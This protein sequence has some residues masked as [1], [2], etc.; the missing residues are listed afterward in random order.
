MPYQALSAMAVLTFTFFIG[1]LFILLTLGSQT[2]L[3][4]FETR[5][6]ISAYFEDETSEGNILDLKRNLEAKSYVSQV[7]YISKEAALEIYR[8][9]NKEDELLLEM[10]TADILPASLEISAT[11][12]EQIP[13]IQQELEGLPGIEEVV[14]Q[15]D[16]VEALSKWTGGIR[17]VGL[18]LVLFLVATAM[19][20]VVIIVG[21]KVASRRAEI[22]IMQLLG[23]QKW[24]IVGPFL[25]EGAFYGVVGGF[26]SWIFSFILLLYLTPFLVSFLGDIPLFP[27]DTVVMLLILLGSMVSGILIGMTGSI[28]AVK[29]YFK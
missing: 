23:A 27:L 29:R 2:V 8:E 9:Q 4:Y 14:F 24:F 11:S 10:V 7:D 13:A 25:L 22:G 20:I 26:V 16:V 17:L 15:Q 19:L 6:Q 3:N 1:Q 28:L 21:M 12:V 5:P 18:G